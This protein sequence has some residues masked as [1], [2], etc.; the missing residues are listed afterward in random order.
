MKKT[1]LLIFIALL[2]SSIAMAAP[3]TFPS[4]NPSP[5]SLNLGYGLITDG[6][7]VSIDNTTVQLKINVPCNDVNNF[8]QSVDNNVLGCNYVDFT[9]YQTTADLPNHLDCGVGK[10]LQNDSQCVDLPTAGGID[11]N[12]N[13][14]VNSV[15][16]T[17]QNPSPAQH[18]LSAY[19]KGNS[20]SY[21]ALNIVS[22]NR[23][24]SAFWLSGIE[25]N[26][27]TL[28]INHRQP[29][30]DDSSAA[31]LSILLSGK[32]TTAQGIFLNKGN[33]SGNS[34]II[35][36]GTLTGF[37]VNANGSATITSDGANNL[38]VQRTDG[39]DIFR[40]DTTSSLIWTTKHIPT[41]TNTYDLGDA[42][43]IWRNTSTQTLIV[44]N[45]GY[46]NNSAICT[47]AN[48]ICGST[49][50]NVDANLSR[51][52]IFKNLT[53][54]SGW[55]SGGQFSGTLNTGLKMN[56]S[57]GQ[58]IVIGDY[59]YFIVN[60]N[61]TEITVN[62]VGEEH[63]YVNT[64]GGVFASAIHN[65]RE[66]IYL[67][68][69]F[70]SGGV[71]QKYDFVP[72]IIADFQVEVIHNEQMRGVM[73]D[74]CTVSQ[75]DAMGLTT[76]GCQMRIKL[77]NYTIPATTAFTKMFKDSNGIW[78]ADTSIANHVNSTHFNNR[79]RSG[80]AAFQIMPAGKARKDLIIMTSTGNE[81]LIV[82]DALYE[83]ESTSYDALPP[84]IPDFMEKDMAQ[85][86]ELSVTYGETTLN[87][88]TCFRDVTP[89]PDRI[90]R[91]QSASLLN[92]LIIDANTTYIAGYGLILT[93]NQFNI[94]ASFIQSFNDSAR[95]DSI[96]AT[97]RAD[98]ITLTAKFGT[99]NLHTHDATNLT[100]IGYLDNKTKIT[101]LNITLPAA[102][103]GTFFN[104][105]GGFSAPASSGGGDG[106]VTSIEVMTSGTT[107]T[108]V[109][110]RSNA[111]NVNAS[112]TDQTGAGG[113]ETYVGTVTT[114]QRIATDF[115]N[116]GGVTGTG[117]DGFTRTI[118]SA[119]ASGLDNNTVDIANHP[120]VLAIRDSATIGGGILIGTHYTATTAVPRINGSEQ[121]TFIFR[122]QNSTSVNT[123]RM[124]FL[125]TITSTQ[126]VDG[127]FFESMDFILIGR[128]RAN[129][130]E[131]N[132]T[133]RRIAKEDFYKVNVRF[134][135]TA[136]FVNFTIWNS[137]NGV[138]TMLN[139][140]GLSTNLPTGIGRETGF[141]VIATQSTT[142]AA[143]VLVF[144]DYMELFINRTVIR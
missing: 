37:Q 70:A 125:D 137:T 6:K 85:L 46:I 19:L 11:S 121:G 44:S 104:S 131:S 66:Q 27:G 138:T 24:M 36:N 5:N 96:N 139:Q 126:P 32:N 128:C 16:I 72:Q 122:P 58:G 33:S 21:V 26:T 99:A 38:L 124:G 34:I 49:S 80:T 50:Y 74:G 117:Y 47:A 52:N 143:Q 82:G 42:T 118:I 112:F 129:N 64:T 7:N 35:T 110:N 51:E 76:T 62:N 100:N 1:W 39:T 123:I 63:I 136:S 43:H 113:G 57:A 140:T 41:S 22:D 141:G 103:A 55:L 65:H 29:E 23:L 77:I 15:S 88:V 90:R 144:M 45:N 81:Y 106:N 12:S 111:G 40:V 9:G 93:L 132:V 83:N 78:Y 130:V 75:N 30:D 127:C 119:G 109:I 31:G 71:L 114:S 3:F 84:T 20:S 69:I 135:P 14:S 95:I 48:G 133:I 89:N 56:V 120:C 91:G 61:K 54:S 97:Q 28:K 25:T 17:S 107:Q 98:N 8:A 87:L 4:L 101:W 59:G 67:G 115:C 10:A 92:N 68:H 60:W 86:S 102:V 116:E 142:S 18:A 105:T 134:S 108:I 53:Q 2:I 73:V 79:S 94:S 13:I